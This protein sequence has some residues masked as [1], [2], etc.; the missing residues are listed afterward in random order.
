M[1]SK[2]KNKVKKEGLKGG[3][4]IRNAREKIS[5]RTQ[6]FPLKEVMDHLKQYSKDCK[7]KFD[8]SIEVVYKLGIDPRQS[9]QQVRGAVSMPNGLGK[10]IRV[11]VIC[12]DE[13]QKDAKAA[14]AD[15]VGADDLIEKIKG[16]MLD[17]DVC[18]ATP[19]CMPLV[20]KVGKILGPK[21]LMPNPKVGT[22]AL[23]VK[24]A[25]K[26]AKAGQVE[27]KVEKAGLV[28]T[29]IGKLSFEVKAIEENFKALHEA[30]SSSR[31]SGAKG[32]FIKSVFFST[33]MGPS[34]R[35]DL[36]SGI[37]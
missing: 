12:K 5:D 3:K 9:D 20:S 2:D 7:T 32:V 27:F 19:D 11:A 16:G 10:E 25:V 23:D 13:K 6:V 18:I 14:G 37:N 21:G 22:V 8:E 31:P 17:F 30:I 1:A 36:S 29:A 26:T 4:R 35:L 28:H 33:T 34:I 15:I 24:A